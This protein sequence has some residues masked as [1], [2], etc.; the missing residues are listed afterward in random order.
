MM[1]VSFVGAASEF[2]LGGSCACD[3]EDDTDIFLLAIWC[4]VNAVPCE[5]CFSSS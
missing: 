1:F 2:R 3:A 5:S 4:F